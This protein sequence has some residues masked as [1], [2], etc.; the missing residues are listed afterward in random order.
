MN[1]RVLFFGALGCAVM[2]VVNRLS[3]PHFT[4]TSFQTDA[5][6]NSIASL[7]PSVM[8]VTGVPIARRWLRYAVTAL[9]VPIAGLGLLIVVCATLF[10]AIQPPEVTPT[11]MSAG[12]HTLAVSVFISGAMPTGAVGI[13]QVCRITPGIMYTR[14]LW[15]SRGTEIPG[16]DVVDRDHV[17]INGDVMVLH[18]LI[19]PLC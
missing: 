10:L 19:W 2:I 9:L 13:D 3:D 6:V 4:F 16:I 17:R 5:L 18:P 7:M 11:I 15:T 1:R 14:H 8:L 12:R